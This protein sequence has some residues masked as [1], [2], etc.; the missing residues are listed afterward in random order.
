MLIIDRGRTIAL[1]DSAA[2][3]ASAGV[4][5]GATLEEAFLALVGR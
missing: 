1:G 3:R 4:S 5:Q 2:V